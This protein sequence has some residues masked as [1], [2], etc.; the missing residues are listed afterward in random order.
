MLV[1]Q[2]QRGGTVHVGLENFAINED[3][4]LPIKEGKYLR[5]SIKDHGRGIAKEQ[6]GRIFDPYF[7]TKELGN[8]KGLCFGLAVCYSIVKNH[9]GLIAVES[10]P[11][12]GTTFY[13]YLP[14]QS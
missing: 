12:D 7:T 8:Q 1:N 6:I 13:I 5:I 2:C 11:D 4:N 14:A 3:H 10:E 9:H